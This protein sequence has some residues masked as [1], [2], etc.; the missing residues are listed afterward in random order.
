MRLQSPGY[1]GE[2]AHKHTQ[3]RSLTCRLSVLLTFSGCLQS[4]KTQMGS[5]KNKQGLMS[6]KRAS[7][8]LREILRHIRHREVSCEEIAF[9]KISSNPKVL[10]KSFSSRSAGQKHSSLVVVWRVSTDICLM[11]TNGHRE[12]LA[13]D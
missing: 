8:F 5:C 10:R 6:I 4:K 3:T 2:G 9:F 11:H 7:G 1:Q 12:S 13:G